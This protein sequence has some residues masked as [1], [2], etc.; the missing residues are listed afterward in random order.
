MAS[1]AGLNS[2]VAQSVI[3]SVEATTP[4]ACGQKET[5]CIPAGFV[6][7]SP[8]NMVRKI[9]GCVKKTI[10]RG[11][12]PQTV[13]HITGNSSFKPVQCAIVGSEEACS[14][15]MYSSVETDVG[16]KWN[17]AQQVCKWNEAQ[18][19]CEIERE[20]RTILCNKPEPYEGQGGIKMISDCSACTED[21][22]APGYANE[23]CQ[24]SRLDPKNACKE[25]IT[26]RARCKFKL[27]GLTHIQPNAD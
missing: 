3:Q 10:Y 6:C 21:P 22:S 15:G 24:Y 13:C 25:S 20:Q 18:Q 14:Q 26:P 9:E 23:W 8:T 12:K 17:E 1:C 19:V 16:C 5:Q 27:E 2:A 7:I 11:G 4:C